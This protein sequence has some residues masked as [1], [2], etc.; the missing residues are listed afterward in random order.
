MSVGA[1]RC[2]RRKRVM[3]R[4]VEYKGH[5]ISLTVLPEQGRW[6]YRIDDG[7]MRMVHVTRPAMNAEVLAQEAELK[8]R[9]EIDR[10]E[11]LESR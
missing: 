1:I 8:A 11:R 6:A 4:Q 10:A 2:L 9:A 3:L 7:P 5:Q